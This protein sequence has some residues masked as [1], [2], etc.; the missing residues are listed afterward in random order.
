MLTL[1][2]TL[3]YFSFMA[4]DKNA[5][6]KEAQK[7]A[8][9]GQYDKAI[10]EWKKLI[11][12]SPNDANIFNTIG[13]LSLK[14]NAKADA[15]D[16]YKKAADLLAADGFTSKAIALYKKVL[17]IDPRKVEVR[18]AL[19]DLNA[20]KGLTG[21]ALESYKLAADHYIQKSEMAKALGI[22]QKMADLN[23]SNIPFRIKLAD[24]YAKEGLRKEAAKTYLEAADI[25]MS[26]DAFQEARQLFE[27]VLSIDPGNKDVYYK[28][29]IVYY[30]EG[31]FAEA[32]KAFKPASEAEPSNKELV[33]L[34]VDSLS[35]T[36]RDNDAE[37]LLK[38]LLSRDGA[39]LD[40]R[41]KLFKFYLV[42]KEYDKAL[43]EAVAIA[44]VQAENRE[45]DAA[46]EIL[47][48]FVNENP[49]HISG[50][51]KLS[52]LYVRLRKESEAAQ[53]LLAVA[54]LY[55]EQGDRSGAKDALT[56]TLE[57]IPDMPEAKQR[58]ERLDASGV[59]PTTEPVPVGEPSI[60]PPGGEPT[61]FAAAG[62]ALGAAQ[63]ASAEPPAIEEDPAIAEAF[64]EVEVLVK[65]G[66]AGKAIEQLESLAFKFPASAQVRMKLRD[67][68]REQGNAQKA[69]EHAVALSDIYLQ[70]GM[71]EQSRSVLSAALE[72]AP[73]N[74]EILS[75]LGEAAASQARESAEA[76]AT[77]AEET[78]FGEL[79][80]PPETGEMTAEPAVHEE[81]P[82]FDWQPPVEEMAPSGTAP[83][84]PSFETVDWTPPAEETT[85]ETGVRAPEEA[86]H[87]EP[88]A[89][90][91]D[92]GEIW[93]EAEFY[94][95]QGLFE[96]ARKYYERIIELAP[97]DS[98][99]LGRMAEISREKEDLQ[100]FEK[101][102]EA[103]EGLGTLVPAESTEGEAPT[104]ISDEEAVRSL[105]REI[106]EL[107][108]RQKSK[109]GSPLKKEKAAPKEV[110]PPQMAESQPAGA[111]LELMPSRRATEEDFFDL[112]EELRAEGETAVFRKE[113]KGKSEDFFDLA[114]ELREEL[115]SVAAS[116]EGTRKDEQEQSLDDIFQ[117]FKKG[118]EEQAGREDVD[119]HYNLGIAYK[120]MGLLDDAIHEFTMT[121]E[122]EFRFVG[123]RY[124][125]GLCF[126]EKGDYH[127]AIVEIQNALNYSES[128]GGDALERLGMRYDLGLAH[129][130]AGNLND[131]I[132]AFQRVSDE[133]PG[134]RD[135]AAKLKELNQGDFISIEQ[136]KEDIEKEISAKFFEE[137][138]RIEREEKTRK[139]EKVRN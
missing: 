46:V 23:P 74:A 93:A 18:L 92:T 80:L 111:G 22:Y 27:K 102:T 45:F 61:V 51:R 6:I 4:M 26:N 84:L 10:A 3:W 42:K 136:L 30:K 75:R 55:Q 122:G 112:G 29:G 70:R 78:P 47:K 130:G 128:L 68:Y 108:Q 69:V 15:V 100:E 9:K 134:Y 34:Y 53:E 87:E 52:D 33:D 114:A 25:H 105:M 39:R 12:E 63:A 65:Y 123:S 16:A 40:L 120:E 41:E 7:L 97:R 90:A 109:A 118:V 83:E 28:A 131:A 129:Q 113:D 110:I 58:L 57:M 106:E 101:L 139:S 37:E 98:R 1:R 85:P 13:D 73:G 138:E 82:A 49:K 35:K 44:D 76:P 14:K 8:A 86:T 91:A 20:D 126:M 31:K 99:A 21:N 19:G 95:Q 17:N 43:A 121:P 38:K 127:R 103:V 50:R 81:I 64:T 71:E 36:G 89:A 2:G 107:K 67:L 66:L 137:G 62:P 5:V 56:R 116:S 79:T 77:A 115:G 132:F 72:T 24:M 104:S 94:Y 119:T 117:E 54:D 11:K 133:D 124:M 48:S 125:L 59:A 88:P 96:E 32:C 60:V 135:V